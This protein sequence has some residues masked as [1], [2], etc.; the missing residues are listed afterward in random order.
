MVMIRR[1]NHCLDFFLV[2]IGRRILSS[3]SGFHGNDKKTILAWS[4]S[5]CGWEE[6]YYPLIQTS[7]VMTGRQSLPGLLP[8]MDGKKDIILSFKLCKR[9]LSSHSSFHGDEKKTKSLPGLLPLVD[10]KKNIIL[11]FRLPW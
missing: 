5:S 6:E 7:M 11:S 1:Q 4:P 9:I 8:L 3:H 2:W 10:G